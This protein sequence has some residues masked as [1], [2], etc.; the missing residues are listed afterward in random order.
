MNPFEIV[1][2]LCVLVLI[3]AVALMVALKQAKA[4]A[5]DLLEQP[6]PDPRA[7]RKTMKKLSDSNVNKDIEASALVGRLA[8]KLEAL[9]PEEPDRPRMGF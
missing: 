9:P 4:A 5:Y 1:L 7:I 8:S 2:A 6:D 3:V